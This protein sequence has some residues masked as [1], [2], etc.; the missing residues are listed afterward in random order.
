MTRHL[1]PMLM[2]KV[3]KEND[4]FKYHMGLGKKERN[5]EKQREYSERRERNQQYA[6]SVRPREEESTNYNIIKGLRRKINGR[7]CRTRQQE[8]C[9]DQKN[10]SHL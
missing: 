6:A 4:F 10:P 2:E 3:E 7:G 8:V 5:S 1:K 9:D